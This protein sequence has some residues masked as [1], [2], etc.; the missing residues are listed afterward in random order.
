M[1]DEQEWR[2]FFQK[3]IETIA[4]QRHEIRRLSAEIGRA[5]NVLDRIH[6]IAAQHYGA[7]GA[8]DGWL[9]IMQLADPGLRQSTKGALQQTD[10]RGRPMTYWGG[11]SEKDSG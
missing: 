10:H 4:G 11:L 6:R 8:D 3:G 5:M 2:D 7:P 9:K 1:S